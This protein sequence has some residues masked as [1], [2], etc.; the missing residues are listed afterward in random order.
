MQQQSGDKSLHP[1][2]FSTCFWLKVSKLF[3]EAQ[4][5]SVSLLFKQLINNVGVMSYS[6]TLL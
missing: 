6:N 5:S 1:A 2:T 4:V 3:G